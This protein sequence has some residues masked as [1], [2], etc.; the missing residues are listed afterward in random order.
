MSETGNRPRDPA[1]QVQYTQRV[2]LPLVTLESIKAGEDE[3]L[4]R[5]NISGRRD[6]L[7]LLRSNKATISMCVVE[8]EAGEIVRVCGVTT[9]SSDHLADLDRALF[10]AKKALE[11]AAQS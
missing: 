9:F 7:F 8:T 4:S 2:N 3:V 1:R 6:L 11:V 5:C 10:G